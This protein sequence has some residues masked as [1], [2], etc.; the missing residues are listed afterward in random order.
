MG[1]STRFLAR[2]RSEGSGFCCKTHIGGEGQRV[3]WFH[4]SWL[5]VD[6]SMN[7]TAGR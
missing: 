2:R 7:S 6:T 1:L 5:F 3:G 4:A